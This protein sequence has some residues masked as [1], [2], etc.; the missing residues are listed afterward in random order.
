MLSWKSTVNS[1]ISLLQRAAG[2]VGRNIGLKKYHYQF[3]Y[4][5]V[6]SCSVVTCPWFVQ[7]AAICAWLSLL[8]KVCFALR[9]DIFVT[10]RMRVFPLNLPFGALCLLPG[11]QAH[12]WEAQSSQLRDESLKRGEQMSYIILIHGS[13]NMY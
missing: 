3:P 12:T 5:H 2:H 13:W 1:L 8:F 10:L 11:K 4:Y 9:K 6:L 7:N